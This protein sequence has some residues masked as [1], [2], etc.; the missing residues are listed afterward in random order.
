MNG[1]TFE[2]AVDRARE[3]YPLTRINTQVSGGY[4]GYNILSGYCDGVWVCW[5]DF[6][7][8]RGKWRPYDGLR[9][10]H[11]PVIDDSVRF[12]GNLTYAKAAI[13]RHLRNT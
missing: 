2:G 12:F 11:N 3:G 8:E 5:V 1:Q 10:H 4:E 6:D 9:E 13:T 7:S